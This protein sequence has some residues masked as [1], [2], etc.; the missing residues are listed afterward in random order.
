MNSLYNAGERVD[1]ARPP[2]DAFLVL[3]SADRASSTSKT[4]FGYGAPIS[5]P[6][7]DF[8]LQKPENLVQGGFTRLQLTEINFPYA[9]PNVNERN[10]Q[11]WVVCQ[12]PASPS[13]YLKAQIVLP[14]GTYAGNE[15]GLTLSTQ[16]NINATI[17]TAAT[18]IVWS[19]Q[20]SPFASTF[21]RRGFYITGAVGPALTPFALFPV[22]PDKI[23][24]V[25]IPKKSLLTLM[26]FNTQTNWDFI[27]MLAPQKYSS[28]APLTYTTFI[29][30][31]SSKLTYYQN[32]KDGSTRVGSGA[33]VI[34]RLY[35]SNETSETGYVGYFFNGTTPVRYDADVPAGSVPF[36]IHRQFMSPKQFRWDK[37][38]AVDW[39]DIQLYDDI[40]Q[41][42]YVPAEGLPDFQITF[43]CSED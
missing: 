14:E 20:Y 32:V 40:G 1:V 42:L 37:D 36:L 17:G 30:I 26:G 10:N 35:I 29:D 39:I 2:S 34:T 3:D 27:T 38:T 13:T 33:S 15:L 18:G 23:G 31:A 25:D 9:I 41:P 7:N 8:R 24:L 4:T 21:A 28:F 16:M 19:V 22:D 5:Q 12:N 6:Y 43:K 11:M